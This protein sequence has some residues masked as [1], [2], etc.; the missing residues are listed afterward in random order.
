MIY[1]K[2]KESLFSF[3]VNNALKPN[4]I[5]TLKPNQIETMITPLKYFSK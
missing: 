5:V 2:R 1:A 3:Y 4:G